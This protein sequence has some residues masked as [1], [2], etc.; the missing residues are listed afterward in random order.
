MV[1]GITFSCAFA[2][3]SAATNRPPTRAR[4][5]A[6]RDLL[7][8]R[9]P[10]DTLRKRFEDD[11]QRLCNESSEGDMVVCTSQPRCELM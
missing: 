4:L 9:G 8:Y 2:Q 5:L 11:A 1:V 6:K 3:V 7:K 10:V